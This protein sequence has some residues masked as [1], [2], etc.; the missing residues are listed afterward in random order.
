[1]KK[2]KLKNEIFNYL[3]EYGEGIKTK[4][5]NVCAKTGAYNVPKELF[6]KR[7]PRSNRVLISWKTVE[8]NKLTIEQLKTFYGGVVVEFINEDYFNEEN[9]K[10]PVFLEL[11]NLLGSD[12]IVSSIISI[13]GE[14]GSSSSAIQR[15][16]FNMLINNTSV[17][18]KGREII[19]NKNNYRDFALRKIIEKKGKGNEVWEGFLFIS[20]RGGQQDTIETHEGVELTLFNPACE[21]ANAEVGVDIDLVVSFFAMKSIDLSQLDKKTI[22]KHTSLMFKLKEALKTSIYEIDDFNGNLYDYCTKHPSIIMYDDELTD[23]IQL[24]RILISNFG[25]DTRSEDSVDFTHNEAVNYNK[26]YWDKKKQCIL[27]PARP[28]NIF[29][30]YHLSNMMQQDYSLDEYF[31]YE[32]ERFIK[33]QLLLKEKSEVKI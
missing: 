23:P 32:E 1:M 20:I 3:G 25:N 31:K 14:S 18:Y 33:R 8:N 21:Y 24:K 9:K 2:D 7:T 10:N 12:D 29:W 26:Y 22:E 4:L 5:T 6:Q 19:I 11:I 27:T 13:R 30:S 15:Y 16:Y 28:T 17:I